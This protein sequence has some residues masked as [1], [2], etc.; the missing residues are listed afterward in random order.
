MSSIS[1]ILDSLMKDINTQVFECPLLFGNITKE[2]RLHAVS[3]GEWFIVLNADPI[4][5]PALQINPG[6]RVSDLRNVSF[7]LPIQMES[8]YQPVAHMPCSA[9]SAAMSSSRLFSNSAMSFLRRDFAEYITPRVV[10]FDS[11]FISELYE[12]ICFITAAIQP[13]Q[14]RSISATARLKQSLQRAG[15]RTFTLLRV[16]T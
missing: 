7:S 11:A 6:L 3:P 14:L 5:H 8:D 12:L 13:L 1:D 9:R 2:M 4:P 15:T 10:E 16:V